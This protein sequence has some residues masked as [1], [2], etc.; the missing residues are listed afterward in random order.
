M[1]NLRFDL[2]RRN[3]SYDMPIIKLPCGNTKIECL[4]DTGARVPVWCAGEMELKTLFQ[5]CRIQNA[6]FLLTGFG[7]GYELAKVYMIPDFILSD[8]KEEI[9]YRNMMVA[10]IDKDFSFSMILSYTMFNKMNISIDT[11]TNRNGTHPI[12]PNLKIVSTKDTVNVKY[13]RKDLSTFDEQQLINIKNKCGTENILD[14]IFIFN[15]Q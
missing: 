6:V 5:N 10:V 11:F 8:G 13:K 4:L 1:S 2:Q 12:S 9:H 3:S 7:K 15:Q 14:S